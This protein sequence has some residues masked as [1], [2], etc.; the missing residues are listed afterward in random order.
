MNG[1]KIK[2]F[3]QKDPGGDRLDRRVGAQIVVE[4]TGR[5]TD[6]KDAASTFAAP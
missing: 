3:A 4:S 5:F 1:K 2:V 6:A